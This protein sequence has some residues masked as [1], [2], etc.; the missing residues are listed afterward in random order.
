[1]KALVPKPAAVTHESA[2][3][4]GEF[5]SIQYSG[6]VAHPAIAQGWESVVPGA[7]NRLLTMTEKQSA[8]RRKIETIVVV[9]RTLSS[10]MGTIGGAAVALYALYLGAG[11]VRDGKDLYGLTA[12]LT[13]IAALIWAFRRSSKAKAK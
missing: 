5:R 4:T 7:A 8:H 2:K 13:P 12:M 6:P 9:G 1:M 11:L 10:N 3:I